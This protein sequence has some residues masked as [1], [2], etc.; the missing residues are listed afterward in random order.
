MVMRKI[1]YYGAHRIIGSSL[2]RVYEQILKEDLR[3]SPQPSA[4]ARL[5]KLLDHCKDNVPYYAEIIAGLGDS[6]RQDPV[7]YLE[8]FPVLTKEKIRTNFD[9]LTSRD[10][11]RRKWSYN[12]SGGST[13][14]PI[15]LIQDREFTD[16]QSA[17]QM[18]SF[19]WAGRTFGEPAVRLWGSE[20][21]LLERG[22]GLKMTILN[23]LTNDVYFNAFR[24]TPEVM[25]SYLER[26]NTNPPKL[27]I[28]YAQAIYELAKFAE[29]EGIAVKR[30][31]TILTSAGT[32]YPFMREKIEA[33]FGC[34]VFNR[35]GS[36]EVAD[37]ACECHEHNGLHVFPWS[38]HVEVL[39]EYKNPAPKGVEGDIV[40]TS[41]INYAMPLIRYSLGDRGV[42]S[43]RNLCL[44]G[45]GGQIL[46]RITG[47]ATD[48][49]RTRS[50]KVVPGEYFIHMIGVHLNDGSIAKFQVVQEDFDRVRVKIVKNDPQGKV[51]SGN[52]VSIVK[53]TMG[54]EVCVQ[55]DFVEDI[56]CSPSGKYLYTLSRVAPI[57]EM[58]P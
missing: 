28:A 37:V 22:M 8:Q 34:K 2:G 43:K 5:I 40:V 47:R 53:L 48:N 45:R 4:D 29:S 44:C 12:T 3:R 6:Y 49:F 26:F 18:L 52:I 31:D 54:Q 58:G 23:R 13:G 19:N 11:S 56:P 30:Q 50:G 38:A 51:E 21:D 9:R 1:I 7:R 17:V 46:D 27:I 33:V 41:L 42:L 57:P 35:Y 25:R 32:L 20:R 24:M 10:L 36:R 16:G 15:K 55:V 39:D 14:Q